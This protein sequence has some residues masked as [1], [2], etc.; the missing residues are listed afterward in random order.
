MVGVILLSSSQ[1]LFLWQLTSTAL[2][3]KL[4]QLLI[5]P[6]VIR[7]C[8]IS[9]YISVESGKLDLA[10]LKQRISHLPQI[11]TIVVLI[12]DEVY[13]AQRIEYCN[14]QF[15][16]LTKDGAASKTVLT[17]MVQSIYGKYKDVVC[18]IPI[19][20]LDTALLREWLFKVMEGINDCFQASMNGF[21]K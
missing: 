18:L 2:Y 8:Q 10:Y 13:T 20:K 17:F 9:S 16:G 1:L 7:L 5:P 15:I 4:R 3:K 14:G 12:I 6:S 21:L 19:N 11:E